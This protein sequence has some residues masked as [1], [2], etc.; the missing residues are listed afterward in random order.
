MS[1]RTNTMTTFKEIEESQADLIQ[2]LTVLKDG[3]EDMNAGLEEDLD[4]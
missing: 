2:A 3:L 1:D 4:E